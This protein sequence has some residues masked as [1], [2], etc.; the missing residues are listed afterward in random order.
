MMLVL[1][2]RR[3]EAI[4]IR[5]RFGAEIRLTVV[6]VRG[7]KVR[8]GIEAPADISIAREETC[9]GTPSAE[10]RALAWI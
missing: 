3:D 7:K 10:A 4:I 2:R 1:T 8:L 6:D 5:N 9:P